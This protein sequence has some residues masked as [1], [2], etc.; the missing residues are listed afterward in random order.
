M[1]QGNGSDASRQHDPPWD[2]GPREITGCV[3]LPEFTFLSSWESREAA[4]GFPA[5]LCV[6]SIP[7]A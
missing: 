5:H 6:R 2:V 7:V 4:Q 1:G 3:S